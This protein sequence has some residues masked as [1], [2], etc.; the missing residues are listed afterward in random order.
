MQPQQAQPPQPRRESQ[1]GHVS[2][3]HHITPGAGG[4]GPG[5]RTDMK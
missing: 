5:Q 4:S 3:H 2:Y 1:A